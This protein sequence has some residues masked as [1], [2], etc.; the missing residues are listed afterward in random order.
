MPE[1]KT[2]HPK[3]NS[4]RVF[5]FLS[6]IFMLLFVFYG[7]LIIYIQFFPEKTSLDKPVTLAV[8]L[9]AGIN[10]DSTPSFTLKMRLNKALELYRQ[11]KIRL[12]FISGRIA[13]VFVMKRYLEQYGIPKSKIVE[14]SEGINTFHTIKNVKKYSRKDVLYEKV[15]FVS[16]RYHLPRIALLIHKQGLKHAQLVATDTR[17]ISQSQYLSTVLREGLAM[18]KAIVLDN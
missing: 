14:D 5:W 16:Q 12:F 6:R 10:R 3:K 9:G 4:N 13:E 11:K 7:F 17:T 2:I 8:V 15:V 1:F 18:I